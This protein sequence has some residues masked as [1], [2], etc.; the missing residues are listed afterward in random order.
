MTLDPLSPWSYKIL[1]EWAK[2]TLSDGSHW[3]NALST[4]NDVSAFLCWYVS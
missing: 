4:A 3:R 1:M 2:V